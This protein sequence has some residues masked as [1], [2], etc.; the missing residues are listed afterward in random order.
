MTT[1]LSSIK[2]AQS[3]SVSE[4]A[5]VVSK[6]PRGKAEIIES[7]IDAA[8]ELFAERGPAD[9]SIRD[10]AARAQVN[11]GLVHRHFATKE[12]VLEAVLARFDEA[13][14]EAIEGAKDASE[15]A[16]RLAPRLREQ[17]GFL[18][19]IAFLLL[20]GAPT[21]SF[22]IP[23]GGLHRFITLAGSAPDA[24]ANAQADAV[25]GTALALG[26]A[27]F[28][29]F[30]A[31]ASQLDRDLIDRRVKETHRRLLSDGV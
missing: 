12:K 24:S 2:E 19:L 5:V 23:Q 29:P 18:R 4:G 26:W 16:A 14:K 25:V 11:H 8:A 7:V 6:R 10:I 21:D 27:L 15:A 9:V 13:F 22:V 3:E 1:V 30:L 28:K 31:E 17:D 20:Q